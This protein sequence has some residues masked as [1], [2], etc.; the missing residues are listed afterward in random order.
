M[1]QS[2]IK[3]H[4][5]K[6]N[7]L[8]NRLD[9]NRLM[10][11]VDNRLCGLKAD[12]IDT[13]VLDW[14]QRVWPDIVDHIDKTIAATASAAAAQPRPLVADSCTAST[15]AGDGKQP[16]GTRRQ[17]APVDD[18]KKTVMPP[19]AVRQKTTSSGSVVPA[20]LS[21]SP[22]AARRRQMTQLQ[23]QPVAGQLLVCDVMSDVGVDRLLKQSVYSPMSWS[24]IILN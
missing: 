16:P 22:L 7:S 12:L 2:V 23:R 6:I 15:A 21:T 17:K 5:G 18:E 10:A 19:L 24:W 14:N 3:R 11:A 9:F 13:L 20:S 1:K 4:D 8:S